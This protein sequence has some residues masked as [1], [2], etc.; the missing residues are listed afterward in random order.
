[1]ENPRES[2]PR[3][4]WTL[5]NLPRE[6][7]TALSPRPHAPL[8]SHT[9]PMRRRRR[10]PPSL[11]LPVLDPPPP[12]GTSA[13][14]RR[15]ECRHAS[16]G[17]R[18]ARPATVLRRV[19]A[20][21]APPLCS[22]GASRTPAPPPCSAVP[23]A[24]PVLHQVGDVLAPP[25]CSASASRAPAPPPCFAGS[26]S[27]S[28]RRR[29]YWPRAPPPR[30]PCRRAYRPCALPP[31]LPHRRA[32]PA[33]HGPRTVTVR[34]GPERRHCALPVP[35]R[36]AGPAPL[37]CS[38]GPERRG[39]APVVPRSSRGQHLTGPTP[40]VPL[41]AA[42]LCPWPASHTVDGREKKKAVWGR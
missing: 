6:K 4:I 31:R 42:V 18:R 39:R 34:T 32:P 38:A 27:R 28:P 1:M 8:P 17:T 5:G 25:P 23:S 40:R 21:L 29:A 9:H 26:V 3:N 11:V 10:A 22:A 36:L 7:K 15:P 13:E 14:N 33:A 30:L 20:A 24:A 2:F 35:C 16:S 12:H 19:R 37:P 41:S